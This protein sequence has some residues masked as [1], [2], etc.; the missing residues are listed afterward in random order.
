MIKN[1]RFFV[2]PQ[3]NT[4]NFKELFSRLAAEGA[5]RPVDDHGFAD[6]PWTPESLAEAISSLDGNQKGIELRA[7][8]VW[9]QENHNG[10]GI[11][12][13]R[14]LARIFGC[15]DPEATAGW[16]RQLIASRD[17]LAAERRAKRR[18]LVTEDARFRS[19]TAHEAASAIPALEQPHSR[20]AVATSAMLTGVNNIYV[21]IFIWAAWSVLGMSAI[22]FG[23]AE[24]TYMTDSGIE[25][26]VGLFESPAWTFEKLVL[27]PIYLIITSK[28]VIAWRE[29]RR[30]FEGQSGSETWERRISNFS[31]AFYLVLA[32]SV[33]VIFGLQWLGTYLQPL[34]DGPKSDIEPN[35]IRVATNP[36]E[37]LPLGLILSISLYGGL[38]IGVVYWLCFSSLLLL[39]IA[40]LDLSDT[41]NQLPASGDAFYKIKRHEAAQSLVTALYRS[42]ICGALINII[43]KIDAL[44]FVSDAEAFLTWIKR[45]LFAAFGVDGQGWNWLSGGQLASFTT[46]IFLLTITFVAYFGIY[47]IKL[48]IEASEGC[49]LVSHTALI[50]APALMVISFGAIGMFTGFSLVFLAS[51]ILGFWQLVRPSLRFISHPSSI[52]RPVADQISKVDTLETHVL[53]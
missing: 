21:V 6:G 15:G 13:I 33:F 53:R 27:I 19:Q 11:D 25:K 17:R 47:R 44:Y 43:I 7:V 2:E 23:L 34:L 51:L 22:V 4:D 9:F 39:Y 26:Q 10:I 12:N 37:L 42:V 14:W 8:Q 41:T 16:Q 29:F 31:P 40:A 30:T 48:S 18:K 28:G 52:D 20:L 38:Y 5:G 45:D 1:D 32:V 35:W 24:I 50:I 46:V 36:N 49:Q 3:E